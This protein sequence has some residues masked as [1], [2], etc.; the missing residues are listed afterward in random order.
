MTFL[1]DESWGSGAKAVEVRGTAEL[2]DTGGDRIHP[3][4]SNFRPQFFRIRPRRIVS[5]GLEPSEGFQPY[6]RDV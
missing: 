2:H 4:F 1:L 6:G 5:W 3:R